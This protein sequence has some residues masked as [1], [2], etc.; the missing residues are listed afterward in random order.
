MGECVHACM[1]MKAAQTASIC[2]FAVSADFAVQLGLYSIVNS[3]TFKVDSVT[4]APMIIS[5]S[6]PEAEK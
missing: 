4:T 5:V 1:F 2:L 3:H 6:E